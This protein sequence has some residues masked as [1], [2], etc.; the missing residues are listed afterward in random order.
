MTDRIRIVFSLPPQKIQWVE[1]YRLC[2][3][4]PFRPE[5]AG[6]LTRTEVGELPTYQDNARFFLEDQPVF[7][8]SCSYWLRFVDGKGLSSHFSNPAATL[9][10]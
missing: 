2:G 6:L 10:E 1:L 9:S 7:N 5:N 8:Q 3:N 4:P